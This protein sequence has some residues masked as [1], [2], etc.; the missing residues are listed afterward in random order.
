[1]AV[2]WPDMEFA[3][4]YSVRAIVHRSIIGR[5]SMVDI[6]WSESSCHIGSSTG[7]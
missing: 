5:I 6:S 7:S 4:D 3:W 2:G 1:L